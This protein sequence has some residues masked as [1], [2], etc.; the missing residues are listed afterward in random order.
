MAEKD[1]DLLGFGSDKVVELSQAVQL[2]VA[3]QPESA[4]AAGLDDAR[5]RSA[6]SR[7]NDLWSMCGEH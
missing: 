4:H 6:L 7:R 2:K 5:L 3:G 1:V